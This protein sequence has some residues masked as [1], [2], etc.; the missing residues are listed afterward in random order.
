[1]NILDVDKRLNMKMKIVIS[2]DS[3]IFRWSKLHN[4]NM[5]LFFR[6]QEK[7][8]YANVFIYKDKNKKIPKE[9]LESY[10]ASEFENYFYVTVQISNEKIINLINELVQVKSLKLSETTI[11]DGKLIIRCRFHSDYKAE[12]SQIVNKYLLI[13][14]FI[15]DI[16]IKESEGYKYL[17]F[18]K[19]KRTGLAVIK[20][21]VPFN[22][23]NMG[24]GATLIEQRN[25]VAEAI[26]AFSDDESFKILI[27][28][29]S[30]LEENDE[31]KCISKNALIY[32]TYI[33]DPLF[34][35]MKER[36]N[37]H[38]I[39]RDG[40]YIQIKDGNVII[41]QFLSSFRVNEYLQIMYSSGMEIYKENII[42]LKMCSDIYD[43]VFDDLNIV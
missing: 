36:L 29:D 39:F 24:Y 25:L 15:D 2:S 22:V 40:T 43:E 42:K 26:N 7:K 27:Y 33:K 10:G 17:L 14:Y 35:L 19:N 23:N 18:K 28:A 31:L 3:Y 1:M 37:N 12:I 30:E 9:L 6:S 32:E 41:T 8:N 11:E 13:P 34:L 38:G 21:S 16:L 5:T 20:Y 4:L